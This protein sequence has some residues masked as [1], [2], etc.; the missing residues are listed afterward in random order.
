M[1]KRGMHSSLW[2]C[3]D[4][5]LCFKCSLVF[6]AETLSSLLAAR[7]FTLDGL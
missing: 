1:D 5:T 6:A 7:G 3:L 2:Q 4:G